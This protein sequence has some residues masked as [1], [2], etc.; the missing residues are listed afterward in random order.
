MMLELPRPERPMDLGM[1][2]AHT[3]N[4]RCRHCGIDSSPQNKARMA[5]A[6]A[7]RFVREAAELRPLIGTIAFTGGEPMLFQD[8]HAGLFALC[9][10]L[11]LRTRMVSN[12]FW[13]S[14]VERG[15]AVLSRMHDAGLD[16]LNLS[17]D[18]WHLE[19]M[20]AEVLRN[21]LECARR[22]GYMRIV[23]YVINS[24]DPPLPEFCRLYGVPEADVRLIVPGLL[25]AIAAD[26]A[27]HGEMY[28]SVWMT[29]GHLIGLG[30]AAEHPDQLCHRPLSAYPPMACGEINNRPVIYPSGELQ[31]CCCAGGRTEAFVVGSLHERPLRDLIA[32]MWARTH[33]RFINTFGPRAVLD[34]VTRARPERRRRLTYTSI[35]EICVRACEGI[36]PQEMDALLEEE[37]MR[38]MLGYLTEPG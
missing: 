16:E 15:M 13:A 35:C 37:A 3:C 12:G 31:G 20:P 17:A 29:A 38:K 28:A 32:A 18:R 2:F 36:G 9:R 4:I 27:R 26:P 21:A 14:T 30:R 1:M 25:E 6:D 33:F 10:S 23:S 34:A 19:E 7:E 8:E 5:L 24:D 22:L 11:G